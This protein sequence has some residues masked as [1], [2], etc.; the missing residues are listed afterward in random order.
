MNEEQFKKFKLWDMLLLKHSEDSWAELVEIINMDPV[1]LLI[2]YSTDG[3]GYIGE[4]YNLQCFIDCS[5]ITVFTE[6][7]A[8]VYGLLYG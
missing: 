3:P 1:E 8:K 6:K 7:E 5:E 4:I 2:Y